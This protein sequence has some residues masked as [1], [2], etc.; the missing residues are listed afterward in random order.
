MSIE[1]N[2]DIARRWNTGDE[3]WDLQL[4]AEDYVNRSGTQAPWATIIQGREEAKAAIRQVL[5][6]DPTFRVSIDDMIAEGDRVAVRLTFHSGGKPT[7]NAM[8][9]YR[10]S[11]GK[12]VDDWYCHT[13][14]QEE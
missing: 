4:V 2:K 14:L 10:L 9:F 8:A 6:A 7:A 3:M 1:E 5:Q 12:I 13:N 11:D